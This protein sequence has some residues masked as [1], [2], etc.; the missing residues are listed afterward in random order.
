MKGHVMKDYANDTHVLVCLTSE[1]H[2]VGLNREKP[3]KSEGVLQFLA[4]SL[5]LG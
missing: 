2:L 4:A 1:L 3:P 5:D